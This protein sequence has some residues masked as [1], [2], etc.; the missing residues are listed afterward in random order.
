MEILQELVKHEGK[1]VEAWEQNPLAPERE[2]A[3]DMDDFFG[4]LFLS[5]FSVGFLVYLMN[6]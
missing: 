3:I 6:E 4:F 2:D 1:E 5:S